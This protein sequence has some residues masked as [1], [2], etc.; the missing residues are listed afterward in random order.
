MAS[1]VGLLF[2][3][4]FVTKEELRRARQKEWETLDERACDAEYDRILAKFADAFAKGKRCAVI[5][6]RGCYMETPSNL[7]SETLCALGRLAVT[8]PSVSFDF[9]TQEL[10]PNYTGPPYCK[11]CYKN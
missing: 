2:Q 9:T 6:Y 3:Q 7:G 1:R 10:Y 4:H 11:V 5:D 8:E